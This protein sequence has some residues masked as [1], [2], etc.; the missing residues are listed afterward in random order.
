M[1]RAGTIFRLSAICR[2]SAKSRFFR[3]GLPFDFDFGMA[4]FATNQGRSKFKIKL[5][6]YLTPSICAG[7][8]AQG[9]R[10]RHRCWF[11]RRAQTD[12]S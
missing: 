11:R 3:F 9:R 7:P 6:H 2:T 12:F 5:T 8:W 1:K 10:A 4:Q